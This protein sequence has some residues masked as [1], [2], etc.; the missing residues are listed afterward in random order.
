MKTK[1]PT[2]HYRRG[3][4]L[5]PERVAQIKRRLQL[6]ESCSSLAHAFEVTPGAISAI[7]NGKAWNEIE[8]AEEGALSD[9]AT[10][11]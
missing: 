3:S 6:G 8:P 9:P 5:D 4:K 2:S 1:M 11:L 7:K 10:P